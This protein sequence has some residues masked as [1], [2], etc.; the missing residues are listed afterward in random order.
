MRPEMI[1]RHKIKIMDP[2]PDKCLRFGEKFRR[3]DHPAIVAERDLVILTKKA[4]AGTTA[5]KDRS[6]TAGPGERGFLA[7]MRTDE[8]DRASRAFPAKS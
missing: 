7:K 6:G 8:G 5:E 4:L 3:S 2:F 1:R